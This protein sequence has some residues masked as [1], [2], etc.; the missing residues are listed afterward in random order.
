MFDD[1]DWHNQSENIKISL[2]KRMLKTVLVFYSRDN[3]LGPEATRKDFSNIIEMLINS[4]VRWLSTNDYMQVL[5]Q[6]TTIACTPKK[7]PAAVV[8]RMFI[9]KMQDDDFPDEDLEKIPEENLEEMYA[10]VKQ[11]Y[12]TI[13]LPML[14]KISSRFIAV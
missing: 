3:A 2:R 13:I 6:A 9:G 10:H 14:K 4:G 1:K 8:R 12:I 7:H 5:S 11:E